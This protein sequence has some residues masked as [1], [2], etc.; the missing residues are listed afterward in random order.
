[1]INFIKETP[2]KAMS[3][4]RGRKHRAKVDFLKGAYVLVYEDFPEDVGGATRETYGALPSVHIVS[5]HEPLLDW[6][7]LSIDLGQEQ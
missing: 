4:L 6:L 5:L 3:V 7:F 1:M 2:S